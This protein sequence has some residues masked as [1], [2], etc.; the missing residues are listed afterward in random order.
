MKVL[1]NT[2]AGGFNPSDKLLSR[3]KELGG[4][5]YYFPNL[6]GKKYFLEMS[7]GLRRDPTLIKLVEQ[8]GAEANGPYCELEVVEVPS[9]VYKIRADED[10]SEFVDYLAAIEH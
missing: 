9:N 10:G 3:Y 2:L 8:L 4:K 7:E 5:V 1:I 6:M